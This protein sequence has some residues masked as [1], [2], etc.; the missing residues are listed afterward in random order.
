M[1]PK[2]IY[3]QT[4]HFSEVKSTDWWVEI[5][6]FASTKDID[7]YQDIVKPSA[8]SDAIKGFKQNPIML[9]QHNHEKAIWKFT[10]FEVTSKW[11]KVKWIVTNDVDNVKQNIQDWLLKWFSIWFIAKNWGYKEKDWM[12]IREITELELLEISVVSVPAN[13]HTLFQAVKKFFNNLNNNDMNKKEIKEE[14]LDEKQ[15]EEETT[16]EVVEEEKIEEEETKEKEEE[17]TEE[18]KEEK[19]EDSEENTDKED[20]E[21]DLHEEKDEEK[22]DDSEK[23]DEKSVEVKEEAEEEKEVETEWNKSEEAEKETEEEE[24]PWEADETDYKALCKELIEERDLNLSE[25]KEL[26]GKIAKVWVKKWLATIHSTEKAN[27]KSSDKAFVQLFK[28]ARNN[29]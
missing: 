4:K 24:K 23:T 5:E 3:F 11:L 12:E 28:D 13:P 18:V 22:S 19:E 20:W 14:I 26:K 6:W 25:I 9:L 7:R 16:E 1:E 2:A 17:A 21:H 29:W 8:F 10:D 27:K 15:I